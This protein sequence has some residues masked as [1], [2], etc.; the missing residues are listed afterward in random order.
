MSE[1]R[2]YALVTGA[3]SGLGVDFAKQLAARGYN[4][5]LVARR[6]DRLRALKADLDGSTGATVHIVTM[7]LADPSAP[8]DLHRQ[9]DEAGWPVEVLINNAGIGAFGDFLEITAAR[10]Q[11]MLQ[12]DIMTVAHLTR[13]FAADMAARGKGYILQVSSIGAYQ[14]TPLY[15]AYAAA[16][17]FVLLYGEAV[18]AELKARG[19]TVSV[20]SPGITKTEFLDVAGQKATLY[21]RLAMMQ[22]DT[23]VRAALKGLFGGRRMVV[24]GITNKLT[25]FSLRFMPRSWQRA[26]ARQLMKN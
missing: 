12:L 9:M 25:V 15:A 2:P 26:V 1:N 8:E 13:L 14:A 16:K 3:S 22:S 10:Q 7:D 18:G 19:V 17:S 21:Q 24:P 5:I 23:V 11:A 6:E 20:V 4:L